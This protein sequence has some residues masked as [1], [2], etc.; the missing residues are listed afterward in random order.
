M[1]I[2][3]TGAPTA[4]GAQ[5]GRFAYVANYDSHTVSAYTIDSITGAL[6]AVAGSPFPAGSQPHAVTTTAGP[7]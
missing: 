7:Q 1:L 3:V 5:V 6:T 4:L 2:G